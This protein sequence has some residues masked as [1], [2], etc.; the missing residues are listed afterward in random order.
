M[1][2]HLS[3]MLPS[4]S[5]N[6]ARRFT[7]RFRGSMRSLWPPLSTPNATPEDAKLMAL[8][9]GGVL[10]LPSRGLVPPLF[11]R[12]IAAHWVSC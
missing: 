10:T 12:F 9:L 4:L 2:L 6:N 3:V 1:A 5:R 7:G 11:N 8:G